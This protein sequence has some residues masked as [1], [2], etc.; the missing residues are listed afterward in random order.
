MRDYP[1]GDEVVTGEVQSPDGY[2]E[3]LFGLLGARNLQT[4]DFSDYEKATRIH[5]MNQPVPSTWHQSFSCVIDSGTLEH[6]FNFPVAIKNCMDMIRTGGH[7]IGISPANNHMG[8]GFYQFSPELYFR[9]FSEVNGFE[10]MKMLIPVE[11]GK[12]TEWYEVSDPEKV[13]NRVMLVNSVP[14]SIM[15]LARKVRHTGVFDRFPQQSDYAM[16]WN[17]A[18][19][20]KANMHTIGGRPAGFIRRLLPYRL[21]VILRRVADTITRK[22]QEFPGLGLV[23]KRHFRKVRI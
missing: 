22:K 16:I 21:K 3:P 8:H 23:D 7:Y 5:D 1:S 9:V 19:N 18:E 14:L 10:M 20:L 17:D 11:Y 2:T 15:F 13:K 4:L 6:V 12:K